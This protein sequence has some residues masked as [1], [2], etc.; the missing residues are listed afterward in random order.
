MTQT[1][2]TSRRQDFA[3]FQRNRRRGVWSQIGAI[4]L[5]PVAFF[6]N[7]A[8]LGQTRQWLWVALIILALIGFS[9]V[10]QHNGAIPGRAPG[11]TPTLPND[12][13]PGS[14]VTD[15]WTAALTAASGVIMQWL[16]MGLLFMEASLLSGQRPSYS[17]GL[18]IAIWASVP[19][20]LMA[21]LQIVYMLVGGTI[22]APGVAGIV[23][24]LPGYAALPG[25]LRAALDA[26]AGQL[27]LF[28]LW[29]LAL[30]Y[31]GLRYTLRARW[32]AALFTVLT[33]AGLVVLV[34]VIGA[35]LGGV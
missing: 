21:A 1:P 7:L 24:I 19:L 14:T 12:F 25:V 33:W 9:A 6:R 22:G 23:A 32:W 13:N 3:G 26:L 2:V 29:S 10:E 28:W 34:P 35:M 4:L 31:I 8:P 16:L 27:T 17:A 18:H 5:R 15:T 11:D 30:A 20:G